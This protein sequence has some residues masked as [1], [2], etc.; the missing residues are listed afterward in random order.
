MSPLLLSNNATGLLKDQNLW[1]VNSS[2]QLLYNIPCF[3]DF[4]IQ[5][6][7]YDDMSTQRTF[8][9]SDEIYLLFN[10]QGQLEVSASEL[11]R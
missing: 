3:R 11:R 9:L 10:S 5:Q 2:L 6:Q 4:F 8:P 1:F 7:Y